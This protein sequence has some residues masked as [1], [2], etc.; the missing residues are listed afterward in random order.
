MLWPP[1]ARPGTVRLAC[2]LLRVPVPGGGVPSLKVIVPVG[3]PVPGAVAVTV[4]VNVTDWPNT[5][6]A[7]D[8]LRATA[9]A[10]W[11]TVCENVGDVALAK[12]ASPPYTAVML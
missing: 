4:A 2:P 11:A 7:D 10:A 8:E 3:V 9:V 12:L 5:G 1:N 6:A